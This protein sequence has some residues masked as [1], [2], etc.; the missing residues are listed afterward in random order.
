[1]LG[2]FYQNAPRGVCFGIPCL[3]LRRSHFMVQ[4]LD[5]VYSYGTDF[6][7]VSLVGTAI[8]PHPP[9]FCVCLFV[10]SVQDAIKPTLM[11]TAERTPVLVHAGPFA[12]I[13]HGNSSIVADRVAL[14]LVGEVTRRKKEKKREIKNNKKIW[15][16]FV[17][18]SPWTVPRQ[19]VFGM[20]SP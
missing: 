19:L 9:L 8:R 17:T 7:V 3:R 4:H 20:C 16:F 10:L 13:A 15:F 14:K 11:Q 18:C 2:A 1:M 12:N 5:N 6:G